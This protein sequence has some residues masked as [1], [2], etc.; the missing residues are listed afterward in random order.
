MVQRAG[1][2][3]RIGTNFETLWVMNMFPDE[4]LEKLLGLVESLSRKIA[5]IDRQ[6][7]LDA[8]GLGEAVHPRNFNTL[9]RIE[10]EDGKGVEE[11]EQF[12][13]LASSKYMLETP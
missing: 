5:D 10:A 9:R 2:I 6:G 13:E 1:R 8:S 11:E 4:G 3:D 7:L 12:V